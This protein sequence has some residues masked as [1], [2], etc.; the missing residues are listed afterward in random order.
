MTHRISD[1]WWDPLDGVRVAITGGTSGLG[2]ALV[3]EFLGR[4]G[5]VAFVA[6]TAAH[7]EAVALSHP[8]AHGIIGDVARKED[9][10]PIAFRSP[11][12]LA[13]STCSSTTPRAWDR[14]RW[15]CSATPRAKSSS[16]RWPRTSSAR[17][18]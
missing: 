15:P 13:G 18:G 5:H 11:E 14:R 2:L 3:R 7:V 16:S 12:R 10:Y 6:R 17:S 4:G 1:N 8:G 9:I